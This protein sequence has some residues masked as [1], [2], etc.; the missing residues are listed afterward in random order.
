MRREKM[1]RSKPQKN[2][3]NSLPSGISYYS[4]YKHNKKGKKTKKIEIGFQVLLGMKRGKVY[5]GLK[6]S[7]T[8]GDIRHALE[9]AKFRRE[10]Y[11]LYGI[12]S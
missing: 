4:Q 12:T 8:L 1:I 7:A 5:A 2:K 3:G 9:K 6:H 11:R 10:V